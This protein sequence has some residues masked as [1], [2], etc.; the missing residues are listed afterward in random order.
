[1]EE[2]LLGYPYHS[3]TA[4]YADSCVLLIKEAINRMGRAHPAASG[5][6]R[7]L[8]G[9]RA[10]NMYGTDRTCRTNGTYGVDGGGAF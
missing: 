6:E 10:V 1:M 5:G 3:K 9:V 7:G 4:R 2:I 8:G